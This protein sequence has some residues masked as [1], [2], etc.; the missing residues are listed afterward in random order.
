MLDTCCALQS[1]FICVDESPAA[2][3]TAET[4]KA[5]VGQVESRGV[6][7]NLADDVR[8]IQ[9][10]LNK[11]K[12][13]DGGSR[14][15]GS[16][17]FLAEDGICGPLTRKAIVAFQRKQFPDKPPDGIVDPEQ[18]TLH[19]LN[20]LADPGLDAK[21]VAI[22]TA[23]LSTIASY[24]ARTIA[25][26]SAIQATWNLPSALFPMTAEIAVLNENFH[27]DRSTDRDRDLEGIRAVYQDMLTV[28]GHV[29]RGPNQKAA[30][31]FI[32]ASPT[33]SRGKVPYAFAYSGGW[34]YR[35]GQSG[36]DPDFN[37]PM[38]HDLIYV[39]QHLLSA[40]QGAFL[41]AI[42]HEMAHY[43]G[44]R[45]GD[46]DYIRDRAYFDRQLDKYK[47][48]DAYDAMTNADSFSQYAWQV[49]RHEH[50]RP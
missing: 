26:I 31:G 5:P 35:Q 33:P 42:M 10:L 21:L 20:Q 48:L 29:P 11:V 44:G 1:D 32:A 13:E 19:R 15:P 23:G 4:L 3:A 12:P 6:K 40:R 22:A 7:G 38:R 27:L 47:R 39:T 8:A 46:I 25:T 34:K 9:R 2:S 24:L 43:V 28:A 36:K 50:F 37:D 18:R 41:Y 17:G 45:I 16:S 14:A 30:F 49:N